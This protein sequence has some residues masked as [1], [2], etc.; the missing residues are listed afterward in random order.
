MI[1]S[2]VCEPLGRCKVFR[3]CQWHFLHPPISTEHSRRLLGAS[4]LQI[5][6]K[7]RIFSVFYRDKRRFF[8]FR[9]AIAFILIRIGCCSTHIYRARKSH[10]ASIDLSPQH[11]YSL[12]RVPPTYSARSF[13]SFVRSFRSSLF[14]PSNRSNSSKCTCH[15][16]SWGNIRGS[17]E[18]IATETCDKIDYAVTRLNSQLKVTL[19][20]INNLNYS[21]RDNRTRAHIVLFSQVAYFYNNFI[22]KNIEKYIKYH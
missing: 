22:W 17:L 16:R 11:I 3:S 4:F 8:L 14:G 2:R 6:I 19:R 9:A 12:R 7:I 10:S 21:K 15:W 5:T 1:F 20:L 18:E 13:R